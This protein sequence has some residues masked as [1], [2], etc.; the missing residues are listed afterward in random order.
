[1]PRV[2]NIKGFNL[3][4]YLPKLPKY[5]LSYGQSTDLLAS[6]SIIYAA[7]PKAANPKIEK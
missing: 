1:M 7:S 4:P 5:L 2:R 6:F 3:V